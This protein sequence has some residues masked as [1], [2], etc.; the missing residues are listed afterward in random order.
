[1]RAAHAAG[2]DEMGGGTQ[3]GNGVGLKP[4]FS[5]NHIRAWRKGL[6]I[7]GEVNRGPGTRS[8]RF[9]G[10]RKPTILLGIVRSD[11]VGM[12]SN[13]T[14]LDAAALVL[15]RN[16]EHGAIEIVSGPDLG[17]AAN[18]LPETRYAGEVGVLREASFGE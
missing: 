9:V 11:V 8:K 6:R 18:V 3:T 15:V 12:E 7:E 10:R 5:E 13:L 4:A 14:G 17:E 1:M 16:D 2:G